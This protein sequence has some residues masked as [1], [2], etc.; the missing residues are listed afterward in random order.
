MDGEIRTQTAGM[1]RRAR[2]PGADPAP[3]KTEN[4]ADE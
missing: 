3:G 1:N 2:I 4:P